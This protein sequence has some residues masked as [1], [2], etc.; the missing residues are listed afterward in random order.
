M[1]SLP[2]YL[3]I[4]GDEVINHCRTIAYILAGLAPAWASYGA[5]CD[6]CCANVDEGDYTTPA[7][8]GG[9][10]GNPAP[11]YDPTRPESAEFLGIMV[12]DFVSSIPLRATSG[13]V[14]RSCAIPVPRV[15]TL[16]G[17]LVASSCRG[18]EYGKEWLARALNNACIDNACCPERT[19]II[20]RWCDEDS[21]G[22]RSMI[23]VRMVSLDFD[24]RPPTMPCCEGSPLHAVLESDPWLYGPGDAC[25]IDEPW[26]LDPDDAV[27]I[28]WCPSCPELPVVPPNPDDPCAPQPSIVPPIVPISACW[29][30]PILSARQC[31][32]VQGLPQ[33]S[34][35]V[36]RISIFSGS[37]PL[38][39]AR[40]RIWPE[41][42]TLLDPSTPEGAVAFH[43]FP[44]CAIAEITQ[45]PAYSTLVI[46]GVTRMITL[47]EP[48]NLI[49]RA[50]N[51]VFGPSRTLWDHPALLCGQG[52]WV[53]MDAD[54]YNTAVDATLSIE[55]I[56]RE[57]G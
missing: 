1:A 53:C 49:V 8:T 11:W 15:F 50:E 37:A 35:T 17:F 46:D 16:D 31:C 27:C 42:P 45:I 20:Q 12:T 24:D 56:P 43:C 4:E 3:C 51:L 13:R 32:H 36:M 38:K 52:T 25:V 7:G 14:G 41:S 10:D 19:G 33:W 30:E 55:L 26:D 18:T 2:G 9:G 54:I 44:E 6:C 23:D 39:N 5:S 29:C 48:G 28:E 34:D 22:E 47:T 21:E 57:I 40:V